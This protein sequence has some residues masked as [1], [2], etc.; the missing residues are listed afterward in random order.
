M[1]Y[2]KLGKLLDSEDWNRIN[3]CISDSTLY[4]AIMIYDQMI[5]QYALKKEEIYEQLS[6]CFMGFLAGM[7]HELPVRQ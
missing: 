6:R 7:F 2:K 4:F 5:D 1:S 3:Q